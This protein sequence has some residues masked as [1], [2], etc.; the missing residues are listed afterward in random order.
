MHLFSK[1]GCQKS[2]MV[3]ICAET[4]SE[5]HGK[6]NVGTQSSQRKLRSVEIKT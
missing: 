4:L 3:A 6:K 1:R 5:L 2:K